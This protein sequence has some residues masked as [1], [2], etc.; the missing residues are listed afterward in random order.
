[1]FPQMASLVFFSILSTTSVCMFVC[2]L[3]KLAEE[4]VTFRT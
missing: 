4:Y 1:M 2:H 3:T